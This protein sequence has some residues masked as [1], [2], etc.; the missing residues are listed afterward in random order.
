MLLVSC[1]L[2]LIYCRIYQSNPLLF[3]SESIQE[4]ILD[5]CWESNPWLAIRFTANNCDRFELI[6][7]FTIPSIEWVNGHISEVK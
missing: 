1:S 4:K 6:Y 3:D 2:K 5:G 7:R